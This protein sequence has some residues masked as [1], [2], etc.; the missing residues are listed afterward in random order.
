MNEGTQPSERRL[1]LPP[2]VRLVVGA[3]SLLF[4]A[5]TIWLGLEAVNGVRWLTLGLATVC[6]ILS[7]VLATAAVR[8]RMSTLEFLIYYLF[9]GPM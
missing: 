6:A 8:G 3:F 7:L 5:L 9:P 4:A 1:I 2:A